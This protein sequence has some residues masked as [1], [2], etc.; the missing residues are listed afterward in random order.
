V[1]VAIIGAGL[2]GAQIGCEYALGGHD[3]VLHSRDAAAAHAR[4]EAGL[5]LVE[6]HALRSAAD[7]TRAR[8]RVTASPDTEAAA[9]GADLLV[10]SLPEDLE[11]KAASLRVA[12]RAASPTAIVA[13]NTSS[14]PITAVGAAIGAPERTVGTHYLNPPLLMPTVE[15]IAGEGT[16]AETLAFVRETVASLGKL[17]I[18]VRRDVPGF[19]WNRLQFAL[20]RELAW[21]VENGVASAE[22]LDT[23]MRE[24][25]ARRWR[26]V[27]PLRAITLGG[28]DT[29]NRSGRNI[30]P[31]LSTAAELPDLHEVAIT[32]GNLAADAA[33]RDAALA[34]ELREPD[35]TNGHE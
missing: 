30:V 22:D 17:P 27:G 19:A 5:D 16:S 34:A 6:R 20:V 31:E 32:G 23:V 29:W 33:R 25:L 15:V 11:L 28:I 21:L 3:V 26:Q 1:R 7:V 4:A 2:M 12:L 9:D 14:L 8:A 35:G 10:E 24:G 13:T 18:T